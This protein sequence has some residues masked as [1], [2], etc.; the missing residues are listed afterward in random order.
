MRWPVA[1]GVMSRVKKT[2]NWSGFAPLK[3]GPATVSP[4]KVLSETQSSDFLITGSWPAVSLPSPSTET[5]SGAYMVRM[6]S[7]FLPCLH[8]STNLLATVLTLIMD[9]NRFGYGAHSG[10]TTT[11]MLALVSDLRTAGRI[12]PE[13]R[14]SDRKWQMPLSAPAGFQVRA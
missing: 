10:W 5:M 14:P 6:T 11:H 8:N 7:K 13:K 12:S 4:L 3:N 1:L 9:S 2:M